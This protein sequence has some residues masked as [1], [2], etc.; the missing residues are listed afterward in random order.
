[1]VYCIGSTA[2]C[3]H[4]LVCTEQ[5]IAFFEAVVAAAGLRCK[6]SGTDWLDK[7]KAAAP[8]RRKNVCVILL[9]ETINLLRREI[10]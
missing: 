8:T 3:F 5:P 10:I 6:R 4:L 2:W 9:T 7:E 1:M